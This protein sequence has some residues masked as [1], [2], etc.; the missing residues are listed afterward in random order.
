M[1]TS[2]DAGQHETVRFNYRLRVAPA[3]EKRLVVEWD[4]V[5]WVWNRCVEES[6]N[7]HAQSTPEHKVTCGPAQLDKKLTGW[8]SER[9]WLSAGSSVAQ[10]QA[11]R[12]FG[13]ARANALSDIKAKLPMG[14]RRGL[15]RFKARHRS[16]LSLQYTR[17]G[18]SLR[19]W[20]KSVVVHHD[21]IA[22]EDFRPKFLAKS[23]MASKAADAAIGATKRELVHMA[24][25]HSRDLRLVAPG[26]TTMD[27]SQCG[28]RAKHR[29]LLSE[30]TYACKA[31]GVVKPR[32][33]NS[34]AVM[35]ARAGFDPAGV[36][37]IRPEPSLRLGQLEP[38]IPRLRPRGG[39]KSQRD[40]ETQPSLDR[41]GSRPRSR[42]NQFVHGA[43]IAARS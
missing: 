8:R 30:R 41:G 1:T 20:A 40:P 36:E 37:S 29:L 22:V 32:D 26:Y 14:H 27:C 23:T 9:E 13:R 16:R 12:D 33:K 2:T 42:G 19:K 34:A 24:H 10:Q 4:D 21:R 3:M 35:V 18:F 31:C 43:P 5:R 6:I 25:K 15:P 38:G 17:N 7:A 28:A 39:F 11:I